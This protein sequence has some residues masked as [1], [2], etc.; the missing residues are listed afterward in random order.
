VR[1]LYGVVQCLSSGGDDRVPGD[2]LGDH[3]VQ[4]AQQ[5][6]SARRAC[7]LGASRLWSRV[8]R[9]VNFAART[10]L[11]G[12]SAHTARQAASRSPGRPRIGDGALTVMLAA[13]VLAGA[14]IGVFDHGA[15]AA[16][17]SE[18]TGLKRGS[19]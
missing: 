19:S 11:L 12:S 4:P 10:G 16:E 14:Q 17:P 2:A 13:A 3:D 15:G 9:W 5:G 1:E 6:G 7:L 18:V 8:V